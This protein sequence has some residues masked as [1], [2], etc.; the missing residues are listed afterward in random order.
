MFASHPTTVQRIAAARVFGRGG[1]APGVGDADAPG[2][3]PA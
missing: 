3:V 1:V 2:V